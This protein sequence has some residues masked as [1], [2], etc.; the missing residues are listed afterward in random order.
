MVSHLGGHL[1]QRT[2]QELLPLRCRFSSVNLLR[3]SLTPQHLPQ[4]TAQELLPLRCRFSSVNLL[5]SSLTPQHLPQRTAQELLP[6]RCRFSRGTPEIRIATSRPAPTIQKTTA[7]SNSVTETA[8]K[9][10]SA[11]HK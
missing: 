9:A 1:P 3:S 10:S 7:L 2:A 6:L 11:A 8:P 5:R 4:R